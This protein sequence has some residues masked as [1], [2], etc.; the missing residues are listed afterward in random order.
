ME[1]GAN[2]P[3]DIFP[4]FCLWGIHFLRNIKAVASFTGAAAFFMP[5]GYK[6]AET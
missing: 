2:D 6:K 1:H 5:W 4:G 3:L